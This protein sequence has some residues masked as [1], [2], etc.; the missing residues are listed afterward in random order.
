MVMDMAGLPLT[1]YYRAVLELSRQIPVRMSSG[2]YYTADG[3]TGFFEPGDSRFD[4]LAA[5]Y[6][7]EYNNLL[8]ADRRVQSL[9]AL[10]EG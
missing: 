7:M 10:P 1:P 2:R 3:Q 5:Y 9:F 8:P 6:Y 4:Q